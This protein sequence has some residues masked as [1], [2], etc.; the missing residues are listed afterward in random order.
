MKCD[1][2]DPEAVRSYLREKH[3]QTYKPRP[4]GPR[5]E[6]IRLG[7]PTYI[8][9]KPCKHGHLSERRVDGAC[10]ECEKARKP[11]PH[12]PVKE[13]ARYWANV[14]KSRATARVHS[15]KMYLK[16][17]EKI[18]A[19]E[20]ERNRERYRLDHPSQR[21]RA[22]IDEAAAKRRDDK[23]RRREELKRQREERA[24]SRKDRAREAMAALKA[25]DPDYFRRWRKT[26][27]ARA[28]RKARKIRKRRETIAVLGKAQKGRCAYCRDRLVPRDI[29][30]DHIQPRGRGGTNDRSNLQL[31]CSACNLEK[32]MKPPEVYAREIGRLL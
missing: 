29:H 23:A 26:P 30:I 17:H 28:E 8:P 7:L 6:A 3:R 18:R 19:R 24:K 9:L 2:S 32:H 11:R 10:F 21:T 5:R 15:R 27:E 31:T 20:N 22:E 25:R 12:D 16:H 14:E 4:L 1:W 13:R